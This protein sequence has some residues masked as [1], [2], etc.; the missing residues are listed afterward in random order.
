MASLNN[1]VM[2]W[3]GTRAFKMKI[4]GNGLQNA[5]SAAAQMQM[6]NNTVS[7]KVFL[8]MGSCH[9]SFEVFSLMEGY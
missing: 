8:P 9:Q 4:E 5:S 2:L 7:F 6:L 3:L 1:M